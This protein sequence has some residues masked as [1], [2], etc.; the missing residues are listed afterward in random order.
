M[1]GSVFAVEQAQTEPLPHTCE[2]TNCQGHGP[3]L[4]S[5]APNIPTK[6]D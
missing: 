2:E 3:A 5:I 4:G 6:N 1:R